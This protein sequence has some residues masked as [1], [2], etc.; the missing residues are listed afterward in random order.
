MEDQQSK[1]EKKQDDPTLSPSNGRG[2]CYGD[3]GGPAIVKQADG[4]YVQVRGD[5]T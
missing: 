5:F 4:S 2:T 3:S 1:E